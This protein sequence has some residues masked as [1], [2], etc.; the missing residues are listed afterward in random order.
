LSIT[1]EYIKEAAR[2]FAAHNAYHHDG[3]AQPG[4]VIGKILAENPSLKQRVKEIIPIINQ[5]IKEV[6]SWTQMKQQEY[7]EKNYPALLKP[8]KI[9][10]E[11][12][13]LPPLRNVDNWEMIKTR[14]APNP[15]GA[16][17]LGSAEPIIF[18]DEYSRMYDGKFI[19]RYEDTSAEV[20]P[21]IP[22]MYEAILEDLE[23]LGVKVDEKYI[24]SDRIEIYYKYAEQLL[25]EGNAYI[26]QC[27]VEKFRKLY[28][29]M[30][31]CP[32]RNLS[33]K[34]QLK[35]WKM[36]LDGTYKQGEA[37]VRIKTDLQDPNPAVRDWP[38]LRISEKWHPRQ[39]NKYRV[40]PLYN[41]SCGLD[42]HLMEVSH[43]IRGKEHDVNTTRQR[44]LQKHLGWQ[45]PEIINV[46]RLSLE[47]GILSKSKMREGIESG[48]YSGW[49]DPRLGTLIAL[50]KRG[51]Q[52]EAIR[53]IML[54][55]GPKPVNVSISW[56][57]FVAENRKIIEPIS[58]RY[59]FVENPILL[60]VKG[61]RERMT[62]QLPKHPDF[63]NR[64]VRFHV[65]DHINGKIHLNLSRNDL[66]RIK[67]NKIVRLMGVSNIKIIKVDDK[68]IAE[69]HSEDYQIARDQN[70]PF[71]NWLP[72]G[73]GIKAKVLMPDNSYAEGLAEEIV[74]DMKPDT[75]FQ[76]E[77]FG[78]CRVDQSKPFVAFFSHK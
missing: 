8:K 36:M 18:C 38:A 30:T 35:R 54:Q 61:V 71:L 63:P 73:T 3:T 51:I 7:I 42:D 41:F 21:P 40:W 34:I 15:D 33:P 43:V 68:V 22:E 74:Q 69:Y 14:F 39:G 24:Q 27:D 45:F 76:F 77:R 66:D 9:E 5:I 28:M 58:D 1:D 20:K 23:W 59:S 19:L 47:A 62:A 52:P 2:K 67:K 65:L 48:N 78:Y 25:R 26:C 11:P 16:L 46:G 29:S 12:K 32:C 64:G 17:H 31:A 75:M 55:V 50:R 6:N 37:V 60:T 49:D 53:N 10:E 4:S 13:T 44:W 56:D 72:Y 70:A 57:N